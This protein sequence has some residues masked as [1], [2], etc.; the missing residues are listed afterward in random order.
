MRSRAIIIS[1]LFAFKLGKVILAEVV[2][3]VVV[4]AVDVSLSPMSGVVNTK[5]KYR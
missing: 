3:A 2:S 4:A 1:Q 5:T